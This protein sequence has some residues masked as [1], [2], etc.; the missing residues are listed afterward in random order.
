MPLALHR[1]LLGTDSLAVETFAYYGRVMS[2]HDPEYFGAWIL[3]AMLVMTAPPLIAATVYVTFLRLVQTLKSRES[4]IMCPRGAACLF[5]SGD[6]LAF[7]SQLAGV[8]LQAAQSSSAR[9]A[10]KTVVLAGLALQL[11]LL[12]LFF[13]NVLVFHRGCTREPTMT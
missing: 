13:V 2:A 6:V 4:T 5:I 12:A 9:S 8:G 7:C 1:N 3:Q 10:G 11:V